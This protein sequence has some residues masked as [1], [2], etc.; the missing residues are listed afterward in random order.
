MV[1]STTRTAALRLAVASFGAE[2]ERELASRQRFLAELDR[3]SE[4][5][6]RDADSVHVTG[7]AIVVGERGTALH[8]HKRH[9][10][11]LQPGGHLE[12]DETPEAAALREAGEE[13]G[14]PVRHPASGPQMIHVDVHPAGEHLHLDVRYLLWSD[15]ATPRPA[16]GESPDVR[17]FDFDEAIALADAGLV[18]AL[19]RARAIVADL[20][21]REGRA[22]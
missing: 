21:S 9:G 11:W 22:R 6:S 3:L 1:G 5:F 2:T 8:L 19:R 20:Q 12:A 18:D 13:T 14:L 15:D 10:I 17:W 7:S 4:P 16:A